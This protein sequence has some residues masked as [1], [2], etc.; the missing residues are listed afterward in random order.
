MR[1]LFNFELATKEQILK[2]ISPLKRLK[3]TLSK[4]P[5]NWSGMD[6][7]IDDFTNTI[8]NKSFKKTHT[9]GTQTTS[10]PPDNVFVARSPS[11]SVLSKDFRRTY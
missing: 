3:L 10:E 9:I 2:A 11:P 7:N 5:P 8:I 4:M 1:I 6:V